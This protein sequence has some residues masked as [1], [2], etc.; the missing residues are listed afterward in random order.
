M[1]HRDAGVLQAYMN[2]RIQCDVQAAFLNRPSADAL[3]KAMS[4]MSRDVDPRAPSTLT[5]IEYDQLKAHPLLVELRD[6]R[7]ALS[8]E[9]RRAHGTLKKAEA[10]DSKLF[11]LYNQARL[12]FDSTKKRLTREKIG[13]S[14]SEFFDRI[15]TQDARRQL[16]LSA[17]DLS[18]GEWKVEAIRHGP[19]RKKVAEL[20]CKNTSGLPHHQKLVHRI[21]TIKALLEFCKAPV[22]A[23]KR[24]R[25]HHRDWGL[26]PSPEPTPPRVVKV[27]PKPVI[28]NNRQCIFC[29]CKTGQV[30]EF[31]RP[32]KAREH[33]E[34]QHLR[35]F[36]QDDLIPCPDEYCRLSGVVLFGY[37]SFKN[38]RHHP[39][40]F[41][42]AL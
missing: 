8:K 29:I 39:R 24:K 31:C 11:K 4:H 27:E 32:R 35:F 36:G 15:E 10:T 41:F 17:L 33:V 13:V 18:E 14:R 21:Q 19:E 6:R 20:I 42:I 26:L 30:Q 37:S 38:H 25:V 9:A 5:D 23:T 22:A 2:E 12:D 34:K 28:I 3:F 16:G 7:D 40:M 1:G